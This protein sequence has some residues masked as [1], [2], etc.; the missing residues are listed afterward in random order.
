[1]GKF[2]GIL[3]CS[4][5]DGTFSRGGKYADGNYEAVRYF[6]EN[7]GRF[8][9]V[10]GRHIAYLLESGFYKMI[11]AP[12]CL[13]NGGIIYDFEKE[14]VLFDQR[15]GYTIG[16]FMAAFGE[17]RKWTQEFRF[18][19]DCNDAGLWI[20]WDEPIPAELAALHSIKIVVT[21]HS[22]EEADRFKEL[23][24]QNP[25]FKN[26]YIG[27]S[28]P[29][30]LEFNPADA[31]KGQGLKWLKNYLGNIHTAYGIGDYENDAELLRHA[32]VGVAVGD[33]VPEIKALADMIV[34]PCDEYAVRDLIEQIDRK[35]GGINDV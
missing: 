19:R 31:T 25:F 14:E 13:F 18:Y 6:I 12:A 35:I 4:D 3:I 2:D 7:G 28:W 8:T 9:F 5:I 29:V 34:K 17:E 10:T 30:G 24:L 32:D 23:S 20:K 1:M 11:N 27:K 15:L 26:D 21:F 16:E 22:S 33:A